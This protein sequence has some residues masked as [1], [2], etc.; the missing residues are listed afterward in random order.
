MTDL[1]LLY[2]FLGLEIIQDEDG[3][4]IFQKRYA[5]ELLK[6]F[7][8]LNCKKVATPMNKN[9]KLKLEDGV[10]AVN[11]RQFRSLIGGLIY[12]THTRPDI[13]FSVG[14]VSRFMSNPSK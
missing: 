11:Q 3:V 14:V 13:S 10:E 2:Y 8:M 9:Q 7:N 4:F 6:K 1:G 12:L 5:T